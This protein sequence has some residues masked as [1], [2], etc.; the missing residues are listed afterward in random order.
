MPQPQAVSTS[1]FQHERSWAYLCAEVNLRHVAAGLL[2]GYI[3]IHLWG[4]FQYICRTWVYTI[5]LTVRRVLF[6][7][8]T[9]WPTAA[10][11]SVSSASFSK[12]LPFSLSF[13]NNLLMLHFIHPLVGKFTSNLLAFYPFDRC[14]LLIKILFSLPRWQT[15][16]WCVNDV[17]PPCYKQKWN[18][19]M[20]TFN[21]CKFLYLANFVHIG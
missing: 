21:S 1:F 13:C 20:T 4:C 3:A 14:K 18:N 9:T 12:L 16:Q 2:P 10:D 17:I 15:L 6:S 5:L 7:L 8:D 19:L 11:T